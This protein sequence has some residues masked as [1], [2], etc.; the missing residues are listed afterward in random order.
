MT[1]GLPADL[2]E[3]ALDLES[4]ESGIKVPGEHTSD[5][6]A[7]SPVADRPRRGVNR[8]VTPLL[9]SHTLDPSCLLRPLRSKMVSRLLGLLLVILTPPGK[10][11]LS[12]RSPLTQ[13]QKGF[14]LRGGDSTQLDASMSILQESLV[15]GGSLRALGGLYAI[16]SS[17]L[18]PLTVYRQAY[19]FSVGYGLSVAA[20]ALLIQKS[21]GGGFS[22]D[23]L[24]SSAP[25][26]LAMV[27]S[28]YGVR[29]AAY[30]FLREQTVES[31]RKQVRDM[32]K[33]PALKRIPFALSVAL[34]YTLLVSPLLFAFRQNVPGSLLSKCQMFFTGFAAA[35]ALLEAVADQHK[36][37]AKRK[38][39][40]EE[41]FV[42][43]T[44]WSYR[45]V[46]HPNYLGKAVL[47]EKRKRECLILCRS[48]HLFR[49]NHALVRSFWS[50][51]RFLRK[52]NSG[53]V[54]KLTWSLRYSKH[55][56]DG[57][58]ET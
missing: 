1:G 53:V 12:P 31:K 24:M 29:L 14:H 38:S 42:G 11:F 25:S 47:S 16:S 22:P 30:L 54:D 37:E 41:S 32:D 4:A 9:C 39:N 55:Y 26:M 48:C 40:D 49:R 45:L 10:A 19:S 51:G 57:L 27:I 15:S 21:F 13:S 56:A 8:C 2:N 58:K 20:Q 50:R 34:F 3:R 28:V 35:G 44:T 43:P 18:V 5:P 33:T 36:Y 7:R 52:V 6:H 17:V 46:R 23:Q